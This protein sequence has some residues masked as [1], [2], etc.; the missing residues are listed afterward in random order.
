MED[1][2]EISAA[3]D[4]IEEIINGQLLLLGRK[5]E[6]SNKQPESTIGMNKCEGL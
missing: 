2:C 3:E 6:Q 5:F 1:G 4:L